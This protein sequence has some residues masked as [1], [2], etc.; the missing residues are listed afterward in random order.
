[1][2]FEEMLLRC[3]EQVDS[4]CDPMKIKFATWDVTMTHVTQ[5]D[6]FLSMT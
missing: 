2:T 1:M 4:S 6:M 5:H 3:E